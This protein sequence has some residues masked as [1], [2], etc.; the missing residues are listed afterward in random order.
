MGELDKAEENFHQALAINPEFAEVHSS[1]GDTLKELGR[2][3]EAVICYQKAITIDPE[4]AGLHNN[5][6]VVHREMGDLTEALE[7]YRRALLIE[8]DYAAGH[9]NLGNALLDM[10][11][12]DEAIDSF[13][14]AVTVDPD[15]AEAH[16]FLAHIKKH[17]EYDQDIQ[18]LERAY[19]KPG[20]NDEQKMHLCFGLGSAFENLKEYDK[21]FSFFAEGNA[22]KRRSLNYSIGDH[23]NFFRSI[24]TVFDHSL[25][26]RHKA[27]GI[28]DETPIFILGL[29]R[30]G[31]TL[32]EQILASHPNVY[33]AGEIGTMSEIVH[34]YFDQVNGVE[35]P[36]SVLQVGR[37]VFER[38][39]SDYVNEI[40]KVAGQSQ[41]ITNK[42]TGNHINLGIIK[43]ALPNAKVIHCN[44]NPEDNGLSLFKTYFSTPGKNYS[45]DLGEIGR[46]F[47]VYND[48]TKHWRTILPGFI[49][50]VQ[51]EDLIENQIEQT[52]ILLDFCGLEWNESCL[53]FHKADR[54]V[55]T[56]SVA[57]VRKP[58]Y[59][60]SVQLWRQYEQQLAPMLHALR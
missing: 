42:S 16:R 32:V 7:S 17:T 38:L 13:R 18:A 24:S 27:T 4:R 9:Q 14:M 20:V 23:A 45:Y 59:K 31:T 35:F 49:Y 53:D 30:S 1:L 60:S 19:A 55:K 52:R 47:H 21:A 26:D 54:P 48:L 28:Y 43:L 41:F 3:D 40:R 10:G 36:Q 46:Y 11:K 29:P 56:A 44:R 51:Y 2:L 15:F 57:Q 39:G 34:K 58:I 50:D 6:G 25:F 22:I 33:G 5:L 8:P 37:D 12:L